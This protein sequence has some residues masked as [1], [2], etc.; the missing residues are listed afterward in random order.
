MNNILHIDVSKF[1]GDYSNVMAAK[2]YLSKDGLDDP[3]VAFHIEEVEYGTYPRLKVDY[4]PV[5]SPEMEKVYGTDWKAL[6]FFVKSC[7]AGS[8]TYG[9]LDDPDSD[10]AKIKAA[11]DFEPLPEV[12]GESAPGVYY[13][14]LPKRF[15]CGEVI[16][17]TDK[18]VCAAGV[19]VVLETE[20]SSVTTTTNA[21]GIF[22]FKGLDDKSRYVVR[23]SL[24]AFATKEFTIEPGSH[25]DLGLI[26][27]QPQ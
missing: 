15:I 5:F 4:F 20:N 24:D 8:V 21:F 19:T 17:S 3:D 9:D 25:V 27:L 23:V 1:T 16:L 22:Q 7:P 11:G 26:E 10:V 6:D 18:S 14:N 13:S 12:Y 2:D